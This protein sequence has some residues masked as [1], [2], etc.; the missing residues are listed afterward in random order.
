MAAAAAGLWGVQ[1]HVQG[2]PLGARP[3]HHY[4]ELGTL[5]LGWQHGPG[6]L[7]RDGQ[8]QVMVV[9]ELGRGQG[10]VREGQPQGEGHLLWGTQTQAETCEGTHARMHTETTPTD[11]GHM[12]ETRPEKTDTG[13]EGQDTGREGTCV[14]HLSA[15]RLRV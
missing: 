8:S 13:R 15:T 7:S 10:V 6:L 1:S 11:T 3:T 12:E 9:V 4:P 5:L 14:N 2:Q